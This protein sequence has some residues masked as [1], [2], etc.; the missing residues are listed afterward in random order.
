MLT[1]VGEMT[2]VAA[3]P[4]G[5]SGMLEGDVACSCTAIACSLPGLAPAAV[6]GSTVAL[7][8][9][10]LVAGVALRGTK[11]LACGVASRKGERCQLPPTWKELRAPQLS[12]TLPLTIHTEPPSTAC[13]QGVYLHF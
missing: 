9:C 11:K 10:T 5:E 8:S 6:H 12:V 13:E 7:R 4:T 2:V 3:K 1:G